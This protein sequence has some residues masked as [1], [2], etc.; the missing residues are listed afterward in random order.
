MDL[1]RL[2][3]GVLLIG[4]ALLMFLLIVAGSGLSLIF[5][6][7]WMLAMGLFVVADPSRWRP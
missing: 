3:G 5:S 1:S 6:A 4:I 2:L 7:G